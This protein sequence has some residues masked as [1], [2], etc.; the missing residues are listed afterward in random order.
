MSATST[1]ASASRRRDARR[2]NAAAHD[3]AADR[4]P[5][6]VDW[7]RLEAA[8]AEYERRY[9]SDGDRLDRM[10]RY[11]ETTTCRARVIAEYFAEP[12]DSDCG[13]CDNCRAPKDERVVAPVRRRRREPP[14]APPSPFAVGQRVRHRRFGAGAVVA[15]DIETVTVAFADH[16]QVKLDPHYVEPAP[17]PDGPR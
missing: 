3:A 1:A 2:R 4:E 6:A 7:R 17:P 16:G 8:L 12:A 9:R 5:R 10:M 11:A 14:A 13:R 15:I